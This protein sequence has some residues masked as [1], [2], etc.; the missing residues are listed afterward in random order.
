MI[1]EARGAFADVPRVAEHMEAV[2]ADLIET[3]PMFVAKAEG[4]EGE[5]GD[6]A[7]T[8]AFERYEV[9]MLVAQ[10]GAE[11]A[12]L[13]EELHPTLGNLIGRI[14]YVSAHGV[15]V[16]NFQFI[17]AGAIHRASGGY[18]LLDMRALL[19]ELF[20]WTALKRTLKRG[21]IAIEDVGRFLGLTSTVSLEP[22]PIPLHVKVV[23]F[24]E[25]LLYFLLCACDPE[26]GEHFKVLADFFRGR[27]RTRR[28]SRLHR[29]LDRPPR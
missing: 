21:E 6:P 9:N 27:P 4:G 1:E 24:G 11:D 12:P 2:R 13:I 26:F 29:G 16:T 17:K 25:R 10:N 22:D 28:R 23:L 8:A 20:S 15:L 3:V 19:M 14:D 5:T 18:L 7:R